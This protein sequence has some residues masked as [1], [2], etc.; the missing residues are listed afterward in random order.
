MVS[1]EGQMRDCQGQVRHNLRE[2][3][4]GLTPHQDPCLPDLS[5]LPTPHPPAPPHSPSEGP[6]ASLTW[7]VHL[8]LCG[9]LRPLWGV[10]LVFHRHC[11]RRRILL[12]F[13]N[14]SCPPP[15]ALVNTLLPESSCPQDM[16]GP[17]NLWGA[18]RLM[19]SPAVEPRRGQGW[20]L[21]TSELNTAKFGTYHCFTPG[22]CFYSGFKVLGSDT[23]PFYITE[24][25]LISLKLAPQ[26]SSA[27]RGWLLSI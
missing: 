23:F 27:T 25:R 20:G 22:T 24:K 1:N 21:R 15:P 16:K 26:K 4:P 12:P 10:C 5:P 11:L 3:E 17:G 8:G 6:A 9:F 2:I 14:C 13:R 18:S 19:L 7:C